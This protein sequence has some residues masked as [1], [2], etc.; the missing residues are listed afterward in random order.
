ML[1][2]YLPAVLSV[3]ID[4]RCCH[5]FPSL[6]ASAPRSASK[7]QSSVGSGRRPERTQA[8]AFC[9]PRQPD[10]DADHEAASDA[11][12]HRQVVLYR[13]PERVESGGSFG[14]S[15]GLRGRRADLLAQASGRLFRW[16]DG[17]IFAGQGHES[18]HISNW[19][20][21]KSTTRSSK[22][23]PMQDGPAEQE[24]PPGQ[25]PAAGVLGKSSAT[26]GHSTNA[27]RH[28]RW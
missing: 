10:A 23:V 22:P 17:T 4:R 2:R 25:T 7:L 12:R 27:G 21:A 28:G 24:T 14:R 13:F 5:G 6:G 15:N 20:A 9:G 8:R 18:R 16:N 11:A 3:S 19:A 1:D 26:R